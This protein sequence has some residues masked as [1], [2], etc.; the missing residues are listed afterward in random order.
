M[1]VN[2]GRGW[3]SAA[4]WDP[5]NPPPSTGPAN[6]CYPPPAYLPYDTAAYSAVLGAYGY[7]PAMTGPPRSV[8]PVYTVPMNGYQHPVPVFPNQPGGPRLPTAHPVVPDS[9]P[10]LNMVN[11]TGGVGCEP[12]YNLFFTQGWTKV[13]V[14]KSREPPW[15]L[16]PG[17]QLTFGGYHVPVNATLGELMS[18]FGAT[19]ANAK[20]NRITEVVEGGN[21]R[22]Y[23]GVTFSGDNSANMKMGL[24]EIGWDA[25]RT[26]RPGEKP[27]VWIWVTKD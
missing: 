23:K 17:T 12:G 10:A 5:G 9:S 25:S 4:G 27:V 11:S 1:S 21:G 18:G 7:S 22:W 26:G 3:N 16:A 14:I 20:K 24:K 8:G 19:N 2:I 6:A 13:H 15:R